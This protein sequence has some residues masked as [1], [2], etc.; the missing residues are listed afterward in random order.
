MWK[1]KNFFSESW[2]VSRRGSEKAGL[3]SRFGCLSGQIRKNQNFEVLGRDVGFGS[4]NRDRPDEIGTVGKYDE[5]WTL[6]LHGVCS[7]RLWQNAPSILLHKSTGNFIEVKLQLWHHSVSAAVVNP[8]AFLS[9]H[10]SQ[11]MSGDDAFA[12]QIPSTKSTWEQEKATLGRFAMNAVTAEF[13]VRHHCQRQSVLKK[14]KH[15]S[16]SVEPD[17][18]HCILTNTG[19]QSAGL[20]WNTSQKDGASGAREHARVQQWVHNDLKREW[21]CV[22]DDQLQIL[23]WQT[24]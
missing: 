8:T 3:K 16:S 21:L 6:S 5:E 11:C 4:P 22:I 19:M 20:A 24:P 23:P 10:T 12:T 17:V 18:E 2:R 7:K 1:E 9:H 15:L 13:E 14:E